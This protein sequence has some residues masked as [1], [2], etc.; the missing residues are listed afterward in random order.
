MKE[1]PHFPMNPFTNSKF[2]T[3]GNSE[4]EKFKKEVCSSC[5]N[6]WTEVDRD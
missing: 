3:R 4:E 6:G 2:E 1:D 5:M